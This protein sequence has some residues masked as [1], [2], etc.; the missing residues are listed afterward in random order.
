MKA[1]DRRTTKYKI[2]MKREIET[3]RM[4]YERKTKKINKERRKEKSKKERTRAS[5]FSAGQQ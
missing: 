4:K 3:K 1:S 5:C 2:K